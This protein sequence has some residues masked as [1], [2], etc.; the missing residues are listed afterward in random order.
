MVR[1]AGGC[2]IARPVFRDRPDLDMTV[3]E[4]EPLPGMQMA[5][6]VEHAAHRLAGDYVRQAR[7]DGHTWPEIGAALNLAADAERRSMSPAEAAYDYAAGDPGSEYARRYGRSVTW[8]CPACRAVISD[9]GP[10]AGSP[11]DTERGHT[12]GCERLAATQNAYDAE[13]DEPDQD[14]PH[15]ARCRD[16]A[17]QGRAE[18]EPQ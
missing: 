8:S 3:A 11:A 13:W 6:H 16:A 4:P 9:R 18:A 1:E 15:P 5:R 12:D 17:P 14:L 7:E 10:Q 2:I